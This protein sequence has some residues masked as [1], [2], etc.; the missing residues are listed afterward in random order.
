MSGIINNYPSCLTA[1]PN[2]P[3]GLSGESLGSALSGSVSILSKLQVMAGDSR[4]AHGAVAP[5]DTGPIRPRRLARR[6]RTFCH[7]Q[8]Q[9]EKGR[10]Y[11]HASHSTSVCRSLGVHVFG[12][13]SR[14]VQALL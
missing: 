9:K 3:P 12:R 7:V 5:S 8:E 10:I 4:R 1:G 2:P 11:S 14:G 13:R 6:F